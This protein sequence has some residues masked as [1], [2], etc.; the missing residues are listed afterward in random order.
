MFTFDK[1]RDLFLTILI[2]NKL[3]GSKRFPSSNLLQVPRM[4]QGNL[5]LCKRLRFLKV[6]KRNMLALY[7]LFFIIIIIYLFYRV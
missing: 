7:L 3:S 5:L 2:E 1:D 4:L 6:K